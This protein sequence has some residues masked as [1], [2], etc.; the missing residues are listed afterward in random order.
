MCWWVDH[1]VGVLM[2]WWVSGDWEI[3]AD[4]ISGD[5][6]CKWKLFGSLIGTSRE[7][8]SNKSH[9]SV[10]FW[11]RKWTWTKS[12]VVFTD[13]ITVIQI[14]FIEHVGK[15]LLSNTEP[16]KKWQKWLPV[17]QAK[18]HSFAPLSAHRLQTCKRRT[19]FQCFTR[20]G[21]RSLR[22]EWQLSRADQ[23]PSD[24]VELEISTVEW[25]N[26]VGGDQKERQETMLDDDLLV[27]PD[28]LIW[29]L[30]C[31]LIVKY[32]N[33]NSVLDNDSRSVEWP[34][35]FIALFEDEDF[36]SENVESLVLKWLLLTWVR[37]KFRLQSWPCDLIRVVFL[38]L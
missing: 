5:T 34:T 19:L 11:R 23:L 16:K 9:H 2:S 12:A 29:W 7:C 38:L 3:R 4:V 15:S 20:I 33:F 24:H 31:V 18:S 10:Q 37:C 32:C 22:N 1:C 14:N 6:C 36:I 35:V 8:A 30:C 21:L 17:S 28:L 27:C 26:T 13:E 25:I